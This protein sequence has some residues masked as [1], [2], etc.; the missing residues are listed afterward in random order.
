[1]DR[2]RTRTS[3]VLA[4]TTLTLGELFMGYGG[5][6]L[7][8][9]QALGGDVEVRW[10]SEIDPAAVKVI[11][12]RYPKV[13][14]LGDVTKVDWGRVVPVDVLTGGSPCQDLSNAG[15]RAGMTA[16]TRSNLWVAMR[17]AIATLRPRLVVWENV[18]GALSAEADSS[19]EQ[20]P[21]CVGD[22]RTGGPVLRALG[23]V[24]GDLSDLGYVGGWT[25]IRAADIGAP[26]PRFRVFVVA[27]PRDLRP[28]GPGASWRAEPGPTDSRRRALSHL[29]TPTSRDW[30]GQNQRRDA[31]CLPGA[32]ALLPTPAV[33]DMGEGKTT[34]WWDEWAPRQKSST[35]APAPHGRSLAIEAQRSNTDWG[36]Y[37]AAV[38]RWE[39]LTRPAPAPTV[40]SSKGLPALAPAFTEW[41]MGLPAGFVTDVPGLGRQDMLRLLGNGVVPQQAA[42]VV[43]EIIGWLQQE[44]A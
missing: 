21:G 10:C 34:E 15:K 25:G 39:D 14:N 24:L 41:M 42:A 12:R 11:K 32:V 2:L 37:A 13:R 6:G 38:E 23:R 28:E 22:P 43:A 1:M 27:Y 29:P 5:L 44:P 9:A 30:K 16:G 33:N 18:R 36:K 7:G 4:V 8:V 20:C 40:R 35:G 19:L 31:S 26:H 17:E 3:E